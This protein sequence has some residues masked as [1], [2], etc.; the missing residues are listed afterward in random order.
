[1]EASF[2]SNIIALYYWLSY[3]IIIIMTSYTSAHNN[4]EEKMTFCST[5][6]IN[7]AINAMAVK[8]QR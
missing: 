5:Q 4:K 2:S 3:I 8:I 1:M 7:R 6:K